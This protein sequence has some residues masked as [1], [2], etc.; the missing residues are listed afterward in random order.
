MADQ[1]VIITLRL[2]HE[3]EKEA[4]LDRMTREIFIDTRQFAGCHYVHAYRKP[5]NST[6]M[7]FLEEWDSISSYEKYLDWRR[8]NGSLDRLTSLLNQPPAIEYWPRKID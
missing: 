7:I 2:H 6:E 3:P 5:D 8:S 1:T 4:E